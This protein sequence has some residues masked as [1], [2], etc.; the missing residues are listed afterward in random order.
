MYFVKVGS[1]GFAVS[2]SVIRECVASCRNAT[3]QMFVIVEKLSEDVLQKASADIH[4]TSE[5]RLTAQESKKPSV[6]T[7]SKSTADKIGS[8]SN[9]ATRL[10]LV[11]QLL[12]QASLDVP[13][14]VNS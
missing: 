7:C 6:I 12:L 2:N 10:R 9:S 8:R 13:R 3:R 1:I 11:L 5:R 14:L 4:M